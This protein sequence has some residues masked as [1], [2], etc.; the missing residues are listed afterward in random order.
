MTLGLFWWELRNIRYCL[1]YIRLSESFEVAL[2]GQLGVPER[3][4]TRP[5]APGGVGKRKAEKLIYSTVIFSWLALPVALLDPTT[6]SR[7][8]WLVYAVIAVVVIAWT[9]RAL[10]A[11][12][13]L[14]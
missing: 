4:R 5:P 8:V 12:V 2:L 1:W 7:I 6:P 10:R 13:E 14:P 11:E 9:V 3:L